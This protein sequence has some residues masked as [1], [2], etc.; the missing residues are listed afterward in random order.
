MVDYDKSTGPGRCTINELLLFMAAV[1]SYE[2][3]IYHNICLYAIILAGESI[4]K[5]EGNDIIK[6]V[7]I[8]KKFLSDLT[9]FKNILKNKLTSVKST[10]IA[11]FYYNLEEYNID[12]GNH[13]N[14]SRTFNRDFKDMTYCMYLTNVHDINVY[15]YFFKNTKSN[16]VP[17]CLINKLYVVFRGTSSIKQCIQDLKMG[18]ANIDN[19]TSH[20]DRYGETKKLVDIFFNKNIDKNNKIVIHSGFIETLFTS[21]EELNFTLEYMAEQMLKGTDGTDGKVSLYISGHSL[22]AALAEL[23]GLV[24]GVALSESEISFVKKIKNP[25][26]IYS[27][28]SPT[29][30]NDTLK[31]LYEVVENN[32]NVVINRTVSKSKSKILDIITLV[33]PIIITGI[34]KPVNVLKF[35]LST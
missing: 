3:P 31:K 29:I 5:L 16:K 2:S 14:K 15:V 28:G 23:Y 21:L 25:V 10:D 12:F 24:V 32:G 1:L 19:L 20:L 27:F 13:G 8:Q 4:D 26:H 9:I 30:G 6:L 35:L 17:K 33:P 18:A 34:R 7:E 11:C 22:G